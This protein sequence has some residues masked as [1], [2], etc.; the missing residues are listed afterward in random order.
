MT[1]AESRSVS[2]VTTA[3][4]RSI[5]LYGFPSTKTVT[6]RYFEQSTLNGAAGVAN[7]AVF[8]ANSCFDPRLA[9]GGHQPMGLDQY[10]SIYRYGFVLGSKITLKVLGSTL[11]IA[12]QGLFGCTLRDTS[13]TSVDVT[14]LIESP[15]SSHA[16]YAQGSQANQEVIMAFNAKR[17]LNLVGGDDLSR[18]SAVADATSVGFYHVW[19]APQSVS[20]DPPLIDMQILI[21]YTVRFY[22]L[23]P[24]PLS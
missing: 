24:L 4:P 12:D 13:T 19:N 2:S 5:K 1:K 15:R 14:E 18:F 17:D 7:T 11:G 23:I 6:L 9:A 8:R 22:E 10:F 3:I 20:A 21:E 16:A